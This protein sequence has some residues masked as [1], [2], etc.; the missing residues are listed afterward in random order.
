MWY[1]V[2]VRLFMRNVR[3]VARSIEARDFISRYCQNTE[4]EVI[5]HGVNLD[6]FHVCTEKGNSLW[7]GSQLIERKRIDGIIKKNRNLH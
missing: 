6:K 3:V 2:I 4:K 7:S 1:G 5:D